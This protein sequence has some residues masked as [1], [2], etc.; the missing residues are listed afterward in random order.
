MQTFGKP[1]I[2]LWDLDLRDQWFWLASKSHTC[3]RKAYSSNLFEGQGYGV[4]KFVFGTS[5]VW[6]ICD[7]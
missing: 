3:L 2:A 5:K 1:Q 7:I 4:E 6:D